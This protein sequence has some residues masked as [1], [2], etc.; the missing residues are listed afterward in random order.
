AA[1]TAPASG[2]GQKNASAGP[3]PALAGLSNDE[4]V[5]RAFAA[6]DFE[7]EFRENKDDEIEA[8]LSKGREKLPGDV[9]GWGSWA[10]A[11]APVQ[12]APTKQQAVKKKAQ[13]R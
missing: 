5:R 8:V 12:R 9:T 4:L 11:G 3:K 1:A 6:P 13:V 2:G 7:A 10:G